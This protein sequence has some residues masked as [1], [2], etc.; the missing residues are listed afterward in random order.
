[1]TYSQ[2]NSISPIIDDTCY[3]SQNTSCRI[4]DTFRCHITWSVFYYNISFSSRTNYISKFC[5]PVY[6]YPFDKNH[7]AF[8]EE[9]FTGR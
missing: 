5:F 9:S 8:L 1:M 4:D 7:H 6:S 3:C 2:P